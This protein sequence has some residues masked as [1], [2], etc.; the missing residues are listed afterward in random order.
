MLGVA[1]KLMDE[2]TKPSPHWAA[3]PII[4]FV[5]SLVMVAISMILAKR[6]ELARRDAAY[7]LKVTNAQPTRIGEPPRRE[8]S[9]TWDVGGALLLFLAGFA[10]A[11]FKV[12]V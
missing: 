7:K 8:S 12:P 10:V 3:W 1:G 4:F 2:P 5:A 9:M 11:L 6:R